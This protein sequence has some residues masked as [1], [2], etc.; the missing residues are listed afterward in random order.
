MFV[1]TFYSYKGGVG[2]TMALANVASELARRG[3]SIL[4]ADFDLEAPGLSSFAF[5]GCNS[6][7]DNTPGL[8]DFIHH[9]LEHER[10][11]DIRDFVCRHEDQV[12]LPEARSSSC[13]QGK[14][15]T[16]MALGCGKSIL[17]CSIKSMMDS[18]YLKIFERNGLGY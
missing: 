5:N 15:M 1:T 12:T 9:W 14:W 13:L 7:T 2:R 6:K 16:P 8:V 11:P 17:K 18:C 4:V 3:K 10:A